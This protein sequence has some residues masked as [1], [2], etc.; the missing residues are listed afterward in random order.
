MYVTAHEKKYEVKVPA[1]KTEARK[2]GDKVHL[3][4]KQSQPELAFSTQQ[5]DDDAFETYLLYNLGGVV[6]AQALLSFRSLGKVT[7]QR[8]TAYTIANR[9]L[10]IVP[11]RQ[12]GCNCPRRS[13]QS[14]QLGK[15][16]P[17]DEGQFVR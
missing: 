6:I 2:V 14:S 10:A 4:Y 13:D 3:W 1:M 7:G 12:A 15:Y 17:S 8:K 9:S 16:Q 5:L 11:F